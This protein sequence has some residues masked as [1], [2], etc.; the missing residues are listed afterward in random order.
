MKNNDKR[1]RQLHKT[2][3]VIT[4]SIILLSLFLFSRHFN[5]AALII[6]VLS[7]IGI[8]L[9][10]LIFL[11]P[12][13]KENVV[14]KLLC[15][16]DKQ[17]TCD[18][19]L[20]N[21]QL[22]NSITITDAGVVYFSSQFLFLLIAAANNILQPALTLIFIT[23]CIACMV[24]IILIV[25]KW[26]I[27][28]SW[29]RMCL[30]VNV[31]I[32]LQFT[33]CIININYVILKDI[34]FPVLSSFIITVVIAL[35]WLVIKPLIVK[36]ENNKIITNRLLRWKKNA[37]L[38]TALLNQQ[39]KIKDELWEDDF[40]L[41]NIGA[42]VQLIIAFNPYCKACEKEYNEIKKLI[43][44]FPEDIYAVIRFNASTINSTSKNIIAIKYILNAYFF[45]D[46]KSEHIKILEDW[47]SIKDIKKFGAIWN[48]S[49]ADN[50]ETEL[51]FRHEQW[52]KQ[53]DIMFTPSVFLNGYGFP[54][55]YRVSDLKYLIKNLKR[56]VLQKKEVS[57]I[58]VTF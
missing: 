22:F 5:I 41:G 58:N 23:S 27:I 48:V 40:V 30:L 44:L 37:M 50:I 54:D 42:P 14:T 15:W 16:I 39:R 17:N 13:G 46:N 49:N 6:L 25:Y 45:A 32:W 11:H 19:I 57:L 2:K 56:A 20:D 55:P 3:A 36:A 12:I 21:G 24:S 26:L 47:F 33:T 31:I 34:S 28:K 51:L 1:Q 10:V 43:A 52:Y 29:C 8:F 38:F 9:S 53:N 18:N 35:L 7:T 4:A